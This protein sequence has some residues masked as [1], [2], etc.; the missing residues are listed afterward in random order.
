[1]AS[2]NCDT[3]WSGMRRGLQTGLAGRVGRGRGAGAVGRAFDSGEKEKKISFRP[4][5][6]ATSCEFLRLCLSVGIIKVGAKLL[7]QLSNFSFRKPLKL[8]PTE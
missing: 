8:K 2:P 6:L 7:F 3:E 4:L 1:M 5:T